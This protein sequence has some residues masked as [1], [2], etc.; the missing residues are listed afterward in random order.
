M[1]PP[2]DDPN[3]KS[4]EPDSTG[5]TPRQM[6]SDS[7]CRRLARLN[8]SLNHVQSLMLQRISRNGVRS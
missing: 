4:I 3:L 8:F 6:P 7:M 5:Q 2:S 1:L